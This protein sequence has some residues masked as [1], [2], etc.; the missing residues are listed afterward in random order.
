MEYNG[1]GL[2][3]INPRLSTFILFLLKK[4]IFGQERA[5]IGF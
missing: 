3:Q 2:T 1:I 5:L 4:W